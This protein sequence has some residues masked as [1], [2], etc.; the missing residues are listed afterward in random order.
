MKANDDPSFALNAMLAPAGVSEGVYAY[1]YEFESDIKLYEGIDYEAVFT[2]YKDDEVV[3]EPYTVVYHGGSPIPYSDVTLT[4]QIP[5][6]DAVITSVSEN[7]VALCFSAE[8]N[9][10]TVTVAYGETVEQAEFKAADDTKTKW[11]VAV[12][13]QVI[14]D[15]LSFS[16]KVEAK[17]AQGR[18]I[19]G[20]QSKDYVTATFKCNVPKLLTVSPASDVEYD[21]LTSFVL[22]YEG[23][24]ELIDEQAAITLT[25]DGKEYAGALT[26]VGD[27]YVFALDTPVT[28]AGTYSLSIPA[29]MFSLGIGFDNE[30]MTVEYTVRK[31]EYDAEVRFY[32]IDGKA[33]PL[34]NIGSFVI[35][36]K[37]G[38]YKAGYV[39]DRT[40]YS[41][42]IVLVDAD[43]EEVA[44][45]SSYDIVENTASFRFDFS[46]DIYGAGLYYLVVPKNVFW[47]SRD[48]NNLS[49]IP[50]DD[51]IFEVTIEKSEDPEVDFGPITITPE[52]GSRVNTLSRT[53]IRFEKAFSVSVAPE[54]ETEYDVYAVEDGAPADAVASKAV[55]KK[56]VTP[57]GMDLDGRINMSLC[58]EPAI[59]KAGTYTTTIPANSLYITYTTG[60]RL[61]FDRD[62]TF[63]YT[64]DPNA[65]IDD[66]YLP[67]DPS[68][69]DED[70]LVR[71]YNLQ[72][73]MVREGRLKE[74][75]S[76]L[77]G[78]YIV[79]GF[80]LFIK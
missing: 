29:S 15:Y 64:V 50:N 49:Y 78:L 71:V 6:A 65:G 70:S 66:I 67:V 20:D 2:A 14:N 63:T 52:N 55:L 68:E 9:L 4:S 17:D 57:D 33:S 35:D 37:K 61:Y 18:I 7:E 74:A 77:H 59:T 42:P 16:L 27:S 31:K 75:L 48:I 51:M 54:A 28:L 36:F 39:N 11:L 47:L 10:E 43:D 62:W 45:T 58:F 69:L 32:N 44:R 38:G 13:E 73:I 79:N 21:D 76:G 40:L 23:G 60:L 25:K 22:S 34:N 53:V 1:V 72:G 5:A 80:K 56:Y 3:D 24:I 26:K 46:K 8:A 30:A 19:G 12:S 41:S